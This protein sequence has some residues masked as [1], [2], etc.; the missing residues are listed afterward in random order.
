MSVL[1]TCEHRTHTDE[2]PISGESGHRMEAFQCLLLTIGNQLKLRREE[3]RGFRNLGVDGCS[4]ARRQRATLN[5]EIQKC[6]ARQQLCFPLQ[7]FLAS[8][9]RRQ[10]RPSIIMSAMF[11]RLS[12]IRSAEAAR[13]LVDPPVAALA[14][15][16]AHLVRH[17]MCG[18]LCVANI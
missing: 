18:D 15:H 7:L 2:C 5:G 6:L 16:P 11:I 9:S 17:Q 3:L 14:C 12:I 10:Q 1:G 13:R 8:A 4:P